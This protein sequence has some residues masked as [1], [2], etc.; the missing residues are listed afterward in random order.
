M[1]IATVL[2]LGSAGL[3]AWWNLI[4]KTSSDRDTALWA[5]WLTG[6]VV[7]LP[8]L[9][10]V[11][12]PDRAAWPFLAVSCLLQLAYVTGLAQAYHHGDF[13]FAYP[14]AR[15]S[16]ALLAALG[17]VVVLGDTLHPVAWLG[18]AVVAGGLGSLAGRGAGRTSLAWAMITGAIIGVYSLV[19]AAGA[20]HAGSGI[21]YGLSLQVLAAVTVSA[22]GV[23]RGRTPKLVALLRAEFWRYV[24]AG[25]LVTAAYTMVLVA[26]RRAPV[27][28]VSIL[29]E[30]S[31]IL[32]ALMGW[33]V[34]RE[35]LGRR[36]LVCSAVVA[37]GLAV[38]VVGG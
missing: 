24:L 36:R 25:V 6:A 26:F 23:A 13:S 11:G 22:S 21:A 10:L 37:V 12:L 32:G 7:A 5:Q 15:G 1:V 4:A 14:L 31:V 27:G 16:G 30:S 34:L 8:I 29:R 19:D 38:L 28:Y 20:R 2:A 33:I 18:V 9:L 17:G 3:H 35:H